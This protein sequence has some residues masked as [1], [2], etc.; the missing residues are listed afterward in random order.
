MSIL[1]P[2]FNP[3]LGIDP[4]IAILLLSL[5]LSILITVIYKLMTDQDLMKTLKEDMKSAQKKMKE[6]K[7]EP[8]KMLKLQKQTMDKNMKYMMHSMK[9][10]LVTFIPIILVFGWLNANLAFEPISPGEEFDI[11]VTLNK[12]VYGGVEV[13]PPKMSGSIEFLE[14]EYIK[15][16]DAREMSFKFKGLQEGTWDIT[17]R[18]NN[19][20]DYTI[21]VMINGEEYIKPDYTKFDGKDVKKIEVGNGKKVV[22]NLFGWEM[23]WLAAYIILSIIFSMGLRKLFKIH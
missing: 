14:T 15:Q 12:N 4:F 20:S 16:I 7:N 6:M 10:T 9:P 1:D 5:V 2:I 19:E 13:I 17:F 21:P 23:G 8:E 22:L 11:L 18:V 3:L